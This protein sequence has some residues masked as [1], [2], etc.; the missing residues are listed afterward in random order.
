MNVYDL[1]R[2][3]IYIFY[4]SGAQ[5]SVAEK[6]PGPSAMQVYNQKCFLDFPSESIMNNS[7]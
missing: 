2:H 7:A 5:G 3:D 1:L 6:R 4:V